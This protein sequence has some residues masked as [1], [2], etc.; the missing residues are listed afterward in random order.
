MGNAEKARQYRFV[1]KELTSREIKRKYSRSNLGIIWSV[2]NPLL[3]M[4][5]ISLVFSSMFSRSIEHYPVYFLTG[6]IIWQLFTESTNSAMTALVD[7]KNLL[8]KVKLPMNI[9]VISR[10][11]T[12]L[13]NFG[14]SLIAFAAIICV[15]RVWPNQTILFAPV[16]IFFLLLFSTGMSYILST[17]YVFFGDIK[18][19]YSVLL[20]LWMYLSALFYPVDEMIG[21]VKAIIYINPIFEYIDCM[22]SL[23]LNGKIP[24]VW[25]IL[26]CA[27]WAVVMYGIGYFVFNRNRNKIMQKI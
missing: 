21:F 16:I 6:H 5:V 9:F 1:I 7:N 18:H 8:I 22:R 19:L 20:T 10:V 3:T 27:A 4:A 23:V 2:L 17:V 26:A 14:Y 11:F 13:V 24:P 15:F 25:E 12:A